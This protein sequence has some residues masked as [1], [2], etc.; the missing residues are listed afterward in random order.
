[1]HLK[2]QPMIF[3]AREHREGG[4]ATIGRQ[5]AAYPAKGSS[6]VYCRPGNR[7]AACLRTAIPEEGVLPASICIRVRSVQS[8]SKH[9]DSLATSEPAGR[10]NCALNN[11]AASFTQE[12]SSILHPAQGNRTLCPYV[13]G[14]LRESAEL[15]TVTDAREGIS[16]EGWRDVRCAIG[17]RWSQRKQSGDF[18]HDAGK[19]GGSRR[20]LCVHGRVERITDRDREK[21]RGGLMLW[22]Y[23]S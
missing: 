8:S 18:M 12:Q 23:S 20:M 10:F 3:S 14:K 13:Y 2:M 15:K 4:K 7:M 1:M 16:M 9:D 11:R 5:I 19:R 21:E 6:P 17:I 22:K